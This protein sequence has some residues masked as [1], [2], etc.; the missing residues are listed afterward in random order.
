MRLDNNRTRNKKILFFLRVGKDVRH[1][2]LS[3]FV[4]SKQ[5][6][7]GKPPTFL[8]DLS[9]SLCSEAVAE[10]ADACN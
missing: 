2:Q 8:K 7:T 1:L 10:K 6:K 3:H 5:I 9:G 4:H